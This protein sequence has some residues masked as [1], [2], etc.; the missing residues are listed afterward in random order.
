MRFCL[1]VFIV[2][3]ATTA[4]AVAEK[5]SLKNDLP[6]LTVG[7]VEPVFI[8]AIAATYKAKLDTG[9]ETSSIHAEVLDVT[10]KPAAAGEK[11]GHKIV[12]FRILDEDGTAKTLERR[13]KRWVRIK[14]RKGGYTRRPV[15]EM[16][17]CL[18]GREIIDEVNL[19]DRGTFIYPMLI[20]RHSLR[21]G[22]FVV[23]STRHLTTKPLCNQK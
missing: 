21:K 12:I 11:K 15:V 18:A 17:F 1:F 22:H 6:A 16:D 7:W 3:W 14:E 2:L 20:G 10:S 4:S 8:P 23:D 13:L 5:A 19:T 9:A